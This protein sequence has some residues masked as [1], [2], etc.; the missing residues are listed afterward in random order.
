MTIITVK[1]AFSRHALC[2]SI[3]V[4]G[5]AGCAGPTALEDDFGKSV[6][7]MQYVQTYDKTAILDPQ[8]DPVVGVD[9]QGAASTLKDYRGTFS[10]PTSDPVKSLTITIGQ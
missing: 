1:P 2:I 4:A 9:G 6:R 7:Q 5:C 8:L 10:K 3:A